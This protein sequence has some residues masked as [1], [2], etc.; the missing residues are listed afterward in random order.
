MLKNYLQKWQCLFTDDMNK[1][2][3]YIGVDRKETKQ[4]ALFKPFKKQES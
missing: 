3:A 1:Q 4:K 2:E